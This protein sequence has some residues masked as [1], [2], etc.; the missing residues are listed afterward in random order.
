VSGAIGGS[1]VS[2]KPILEGQR[3]S[4]MMAANSELT[5]SAR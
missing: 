3:K 1:L 4:M 2:E 5:P